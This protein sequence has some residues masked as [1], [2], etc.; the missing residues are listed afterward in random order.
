MTL[1][2]RLDAL[3]EALNNTTAALQAVAGLAAGGT[4][5][6]AAA[7]PAE[8]AAGKKPTA[9]EKKAAE[10][11]AAAA[12]GDDAVVSK[13]TTDAV[14]AWLG[15]FAKEEDKANPEGVHPEV[16]ARREA[17]KKAYTGLKVAKLGDVKGAAEVKR[18]EDWFEK[19]KAADKGFGIGRFAADPEPAGG[20]D[21]DME[22]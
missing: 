7:A 3:T 17:L 12:S 11:A 9:A 19:A 1:E 15:E 16:T 4:A 6:A 18:F 21:D 22:I 10:A 13:E 2:D 20:G 8:K 5:P 14:L